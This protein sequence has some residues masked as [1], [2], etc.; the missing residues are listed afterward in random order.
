MMS[1]SLKDLQFFDVV[2]SVIDFVIVYFFVY[3]LLL[4]LKK[5][6]SYILLKGFFVLFLIFG[7]SFFFKLQTI[8]WILGEVATILIVFITVIFQ[9][10]I[11][12]FI[13]RIGA[14]K[15]ILSIFLVKEKQVSNIKKIMM[16]IDILLQKKIGALIVIERTFNLDEY[17]SSGIPLNAAISSELLVSLFWPG[18]PTHDGAIIIRESKIA[19]AGSFLPLSSSAYIER[20]LGTRHRAAIGLSE[21]TDAVV[22]V[23][24][25]ETGL[26]SLVEN[27]VM[28]RYISKEDIELKLREIQNEE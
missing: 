10:E 21:L 28:N 23:L 2:I 17:I 15:N 8:N 3:R 6:R 11:R 18:S 1:F 16:A 7:I 5:S 26:M 25:E 4:L 13:E 24:S 22:I 9:P 20:R 27:G 12:Q 19:S 14:T